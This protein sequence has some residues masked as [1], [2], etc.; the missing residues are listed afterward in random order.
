MPEGSV[1]RLEARGEI[2]GPVDM[3]FAGPRGGAKS[4]WQGILTDGPSPAR[5]RRGDS[6]GMPKKA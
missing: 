6:R 2:Q 3:L 5:E 1:W 4:P